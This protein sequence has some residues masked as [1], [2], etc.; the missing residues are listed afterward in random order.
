MDF[1]SDELK[2]A[3]VS[4]M[5]RKDEIEEQNKWV[6]IIKQRQNIHVWET[7]ATYTVVWTL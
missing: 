4:M 7:I 1:I 2:K 6:Y 3:V 5:L